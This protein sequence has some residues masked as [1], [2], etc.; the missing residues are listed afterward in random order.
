MASLGG[1]DS[2]FFFKDVAP[3]RLIVLL[4]MAPYSEAQIGINGILKFLIKGHKV[5]SREVG[6]DPRGYSQSLPMGLS[7]IIK[8]TFLSQKERK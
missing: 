1:R 8:G 5:K 4:R 7:V 6:V 3:D 2:H